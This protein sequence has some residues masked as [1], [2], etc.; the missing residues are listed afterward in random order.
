M[1]NGY[2]N[3]YGI[4]GG[5]KKYEIP[6]QFVRFHKKSSN[7]PETNR[8]SID[9]SANTIFYNMLEQNVGRSFYDRAYALHEAYT[10]AQEV[11]ARYQ[12]ADAEYQ[13]QESM[14]KS[15][16]AE[17]AYALNTFKV[18]SA[19]IE[20]LSDAE[21][22]ALN[23]ANNKIGEVNAKLKTL[24]MPKPTK[25][26]VIRSLQNLASVRQN[27][28][29]DSLKNEGNEILGKMS[30]DSFRQEIAQD[31][32][33]STLLVGQ[34]REE[35]RVRQ[36]S[37]AMMSLASME[38]YGLTREAG[39]VDKFL[40]QMQTKGLE[41]DITSFAE[42]SE[43]NNAMIKM[44][45]MVSDSSY[46]LYS[47]PKFAK[48]CEI[49]CDKVIESV[50]NK[51]QLGYQELFE[52]IRDNTNLPNRTDTSMTKLFRPTEYMTPSMQDSRVDYLIR[53]AATATMSDQGL[54]KIQNVGFSLV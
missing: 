43:A 15:L 23:S 3:L 16:E 42:R 8:I 24:N 6:D 29:I 50:G 10:E 9:R 32:V 31:F 4:N 48:A 41:S 28:D 51:K 19:N 39:Q 25:E 53:R 7:G 5:Q 14:R 13:A 22:E 45:D 40:E 54:S 36:C 37:D 52:T 38:V 27:V 1:I 17:K 47:Y 26:D 46:E 2:E 12:K 20:F 30:G 44:G 33:D 35:G 11:V 49:S 34:E 21:R 18:L